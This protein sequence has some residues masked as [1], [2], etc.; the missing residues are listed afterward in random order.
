MNSASP[1]SIMSVGGTNRGSLR[2]ASAFAGGDADWESV[3]A[4]TLSF[5]FG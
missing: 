1:V 2:V 3:S 4:M 5:S